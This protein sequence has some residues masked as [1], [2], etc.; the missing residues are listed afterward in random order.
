ML[1]KLRLLIVLISDIFYSEL[2]IQATCYALR[3][4][5]SV[6]CAEIPLLMNAAYTCE[7]EIIE[8]S[9]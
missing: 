7:T 4:W 5:Q 6:T 8:T 3:E 1:Y 9:N 2:S